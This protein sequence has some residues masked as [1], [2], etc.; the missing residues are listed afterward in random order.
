MIK[1]IELICQ[2]VDICTDF[3]RCNLLI[4]CVHHIVEPQRLKHE[5]L[6]IFILRRKYLKSFQTSSALLV[7]VQ[8][9]L[10]TDDRIED[11]R[12][13]IPLKRSKPVNIKDVVF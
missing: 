13:C 8:D 9:R 7:F 2:L 11:I 1:L 10:D 5:S 4:H 3:V 12:S 6:F